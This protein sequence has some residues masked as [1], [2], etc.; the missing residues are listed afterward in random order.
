M[1]ANTPLSEVTVTRVRRPTRPQR[2]VERRTRPGRLQNRHREVGRALHCRVAQQ[3][4][5]HFDASAFSW[6]G[7]E[8]N[9]ATHLTHALTHADQTQSA[10]MN[11]MIRV[12]ALAIVS[13]E[14]LNLLNRI[15]EFHVNGCAA[16]VTD[17]V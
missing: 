9:G 16:V 7:I 1:R 15:S 13:D 4:H 5:G 2:A 10:V 12:E 14:Q 6:R 8:L 3:R 17:S 11:G